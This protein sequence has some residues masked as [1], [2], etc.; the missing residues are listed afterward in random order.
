M[1]RKRGDFTFHVGI[2][3]GLAAYFAGLLVWFGSMFAGGGPEEHAVMSVVIPVVFGLG[4]MTV[5][6]LGLIVMEGRR[7]DRG[8]EGHQ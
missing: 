8:G 1:S 2:I 4:V 3:V 5:I 7:A 6:G